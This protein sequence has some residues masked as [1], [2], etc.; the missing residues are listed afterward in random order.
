MQ[1][2]FVV[3]HGEPHRKLQLSN[4]EFDQHV[5]SLKTETVGQVEVVQLVRNF[6][7]SDCS[8]FL[9][10]GE[11]KEINPKIL[12]RAL[13]DIDADPMVAGF[14]Y[15]WENCTKPYFIP[16]L[17]QDFF[18]VKRK[19][20]VD[21]MI[22]KKDF[23]RG[24][25]TIL[26]A[27]FRANR[28]GYRFVGRPEI[29][30]RL[31]V[32]FFDKSNPDL[33]HYDAII[34]NYLGS[35]DRAWNTYTSQFRLENV[36]KRILLDLNHLNASYNGALVASHSL[37]QAIYRN[38]IDA[39][40]TI[41]SSLAVK[42]F[43]NLE[44]QFPKWSWLS[45][46]DAMNHVFEIVFEFG[47]P[48]FFERV[49]FFNRNCFSVFFLFHDVIA[50]DCLYIRQVFPD[51]DRLW[52][53]WTRYA[54]GLIFNSQYTRDL[55]NAR[56]PAS[57]QI[58]GATC[59]HSTSFEDFKELNASTLASDEISLV[60]PSQRYFLIFGNFFHHKYIKETIETILP[61]L[62]T[63]ES[64]VIVGAF[65]GHND[66]KII[67]L[68]SGHYTKKQIND[69]YKGALAV[70]YPSQYEGFGLP[71][72]EAMA[73]DKIVFARD[74]PLVREIMSNWDGPGGVILFADNEELK[75]KF[76]LFS[77][78]KPVDVLKGQATEVNN[79]DHVAARTIDFILRTHESECNFRQVEERFRGF[80]LIQAVQE[81]SRRNS[82]NPFTLFKGLVD[83][84]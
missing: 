21:F 1:R 19:F 53:Y 81:Q 71:V 83:Q 34:S 24:E 56:F 47:Q 32:G 41:C 55:I 59:L 37:A 33:K 64:L 72:P 27:S 43:L 75:T 22:T 77:A 58:P 17:T 45:S 48:W 63:G 8:H 80:E 26:E 68:S 73:H 52:R 60:D 25:Q 2:I 51:L 82:A 76:E 42:D 40:V 18:C 30:Y 69:L 50:W 15:A 6:I 44:D 31:D 23:F 29:P 57:K 38:G 14:Q 13:A 35:Q 20:V 49:T 9:Y 16:F 46:T 70:L 66:G 10:L 3:K 78:N 12:A 65:E 36:T 79:W 84:S 4:F 7:E 5:L 62:A 28:A 11:N 39:E 54:S 74:T 61:L 67:H